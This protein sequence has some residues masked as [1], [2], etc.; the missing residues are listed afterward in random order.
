MRPTM[1]SLWT[2]YQNY[3]LR[4]EALGFS[5]DVSRMRFE[6]DFF[7]KM[8][9]LT[10]K[11]FAQMQALEG[12][13]IA[14]PD[15]GRMVGHY[16]LRAPHLAPNQEL[17]EEVEQTNAAIEAFAREI[18]QAGHFWGPSSCRM[19]WDPGWIRCGSI[20]L[21]TRTPPAWSGCST[22]WRRVWIARLRW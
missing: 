10:T 17:R 18:H 15:E 22:G 21:T 13:A 19:H 16:W 4:N 7:A 14:N 2:R 11:A 6:D 8:A 3:F 12:G 1:N 9:P 5:L 20:I